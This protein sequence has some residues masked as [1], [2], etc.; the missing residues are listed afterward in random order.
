MTHAIEAAGVWKKFRRG[1]VHDSLRDLIPALAG[2]LRGRGGP[3]TE[4]AAGD[5]WAVRELSF[6]VEPGDSLGIIGPNGAGKS[7]VLK[8]VT[9]ILRPTRGTMRAT[10][11][12]GALIEIAAGFH[13]DLSGRENVY[14]Q[15]A[16]MGMRQAEIRRKFDE[17]VEFSG[18]P[19]FI[20]TPV[21]RYSSGMNARLGFA[22]AAHL[23]PDVLV[24]DEVLAV[25]DFAFQEKAFG[26]ISQVARAGIPVIVV[27]HQLDR[28][29][30]LCNRA[31]LLDRGR[32][33]TEGAPRECIAAYVMAGSREQAA[34]AG[35]TAH[36][37]RLRAVEVRTPQPIRSGGEMEVELTGDVA[38]PGPAAHEVIEIRL[39]A[40][41]TGELI[42]ATSTDRC[43][44]DLPR[45]G[46]LRLSIALQMNVPLGLY[47]VETAVYSTR[48]QRVVAQ[49]PFATVNVRE[50]ATFWGSVQLNARMRAASAVPVVPA[51]S[52][53]PAVPAAAA[54]GGAR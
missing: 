5:F 36:P 41:Q 9:R 50:G 31:L 11:R 29:S 28:V 47:A 51:M 25:G 16:I 26:R 27:S 48:A 22:I 53:V 3:P 39:R 35:D 42:Y 44:I 34:A 6:R 15:G 10:G 24:I 43:G 20:D 19:D 8:L 52:D 32:V 49:G 40:M 23:E 7:T 21:K 17:I 54:A 1:Q 4:L 12:V 13:P 18:I 37:V 2:R 46:P 14:L 30:Q 33:V 45:G 38:A